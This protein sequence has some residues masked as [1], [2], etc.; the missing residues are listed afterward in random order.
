MVDSVC[1]FVVIPNTAEDVVTAVQFAADFCLKVAALG[2]GHQLAGL[3][4][5]A[6]GMTIKMQNFRNISFDPTTN[7][8]TVGVWH[9]PTAVLH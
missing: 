5:P 3:A 8:A 9:L 2:T 6:A 1:S 7:I 4:L